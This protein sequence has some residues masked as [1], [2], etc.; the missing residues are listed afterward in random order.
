MN[1]AS[2][3]LK[4]S[5]HTART[6]SLKEELY[7]FSLACPVRIASIPTLVLWGHYYV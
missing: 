7:G 5:Y 6:F 4:L 2:L 1:V 3:T